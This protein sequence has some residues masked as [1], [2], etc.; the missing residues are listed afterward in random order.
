MDGPATIQSILQRRLP[1]GLRPVAFLIS[2][3]LCAAVGYAYVAEIDEVV[4]VPGVM[5]WS[6]PKVVISSPDLAVV[7]SIHVDVAQAV[8]AGEVLATVRFLEAE[9]TYKALQVEAV[10]TLARIERLRAE[11]SGTEMPATPG[12]DFVA[13]VAELGPAPAVDL[14]L[15]WRDHNERYRERQA[16][17]RQARDVVAG[18]IVKLEQ[19]IELGRA[20]VQQLEDRLPLYAEIEEMRRALAESTAGSRLTYLQAT[21]DRL[22]AE[23]Q[24]TAA[25][26]ATVEAET[27]LARE[28]GRLQSIEDSW[29]SE[30]GRDLEEARR[31]R[32]L[33]ATRLAVEANRARLT[34]IVAPEDAI[35]LERADRAAGSVVQKGERLFTMIPRSGEAGVRL[36]IPAGDIAQIQPQAPVR[37]KF[38]SLPFQ[39]HGHLDGVLDSVSTDAMPFA[40]GEE[41]GGEPV[42]YANATIEPDSR[43]SNVPDGFM[44]LPGMPLQAELVVGTRRLYTYFTY[45]LQQAGARA[46]REGEVGPQ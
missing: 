1:L 19:Q 38:A 40:A 8:K 20:S 45:P 6:S 15:V 41:G 35:I 42:Y 43:L 17:H 4:T 12:A 3:T 24:V 25:R 23:S 29:H 36:M 22:T 46:M 27:E 9:A 34:R 11:Q 10:E 5:T 16:L 32:N 37:I 28:R 13:A 14:G 30:I 39:R 2:L 44:L 21:Q 26:R 33:L 7:E 31:D 18:N